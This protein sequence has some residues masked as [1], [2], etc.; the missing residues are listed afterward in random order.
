MHLLWKLTFGVSFYW[1]YLTFLLWFNIIWWKMFTR[2]EWMSTEDGIL[3]MWLML[4]VVLQAIMRLEMK[5][6]FELQKD[7]KRTLHWRNYVFMVCFPL[8]HSSFIVAALTLSSPKSNLF[9]VKGELTLSHIYVINVE[10]MNDRLSNWGCRCQENGRNVGKECISDEDWP[11][12]WVSTEHTSL[13]WCDLIS[14]GERCS[15]KR[16]EC[17]LR[18]GC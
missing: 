1:T 15:P 17:S 9:D 2:R 18:M 7:W 5:E 6:P 10:W 13:F 16:G 3:M 12:G 8:L 14:F 4:C 11:S